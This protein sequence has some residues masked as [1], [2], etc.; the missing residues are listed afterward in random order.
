MAQLPQAAVPFVSLK[1]QKTRVSTQASG[2]QAKSLLVY[3]RATRY[4]H[5]RRWRLL[6]AYN[7]PILMG[8]VFRNKKEYPNSDLI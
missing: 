5:I 2:N 3:L 6:K 1:L 7:Y 8:I 4:H